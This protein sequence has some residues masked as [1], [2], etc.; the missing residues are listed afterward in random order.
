MADAPDTRPVRA[1]EQLDWAALDGYLRETLPGVA[2]VE[3]EGSASLTVEQFPGGHSNLT[4]LLRFGG[5]EFV[6]RRPPFGPVAPKAHDMAREFR[7]LQ[8]LHP[9]FPLAPRP[10]LLCED[11]QIV[12]ATFYVMERRRGLVVRSEEPAELAGKAAE[13]RRAS[14]ALVDALAA[15]HAVD[16]MAHGLDALGK[17]AGFVERQVRGWAERWHRSQT[18]ELAEMDAL[19]AWLVGRL[20]PDPV[21]PTLVHGDYKLDN[22]MLDAGDVG[23]VVG[24]FDWEMSAVGDPLVDVGIL[25]GYWV[26]TAKGLQRDSVSAVTNREGWFTR[27]EVIERYGSRTGFDLSRLGFY[28][29]FAVFKLAVV[30]QQIFFRYRRGQTDD[31]RFAALGER[32]S[33]LARVASELAGKA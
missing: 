9:V 6:L 20:P 15:L 2:G 33:W 5:R 11:A 10:Y 30:L 18:E 32:V 1:S 28:E 23:R 27:E 14:A 8:S 21:W 12:G 26:H 16:I 22:V 19:A 29:V 7:I 13:R 25:L 4:Y 3:L 24:V 17:S 31:P